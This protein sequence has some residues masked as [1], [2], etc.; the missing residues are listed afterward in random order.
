MCPGPTA[1]LL[2]FLFLAFAGAWVPWLALLWNEQLP[3]QIALPGLLAPALAAIVVTS[4]D[5]GAPAVRA[6]LRPLSQARFPFGYWLLAAGTMPLAYA[7][8]ALAVGSGHTGFSVSHGRAWWFLPISFIYLFG[9]TAG[10]EI[11]WRG[12]AVPRLLGLGIAPIRAS[13][14]VGAIWGIWHLPL[15]L[16]EAAQAR[17]LLLF[18]VLTM[19]LSVI[20]TAVQLRTSSLLP[21]LLIHASTDLMP[22]VIDT[23]SLGWKF[24]MVTDLIVVAIAG[25][26]HRRLMS[27]CDLRDEELREAAGAWSDRR[28]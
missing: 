17:D 20:Y 6:L 22:R 26:T 8:A 7:I 10:E 3:T 27:S 11:G 21:A 23:S 1:G 12:Y 5:G 18:M 25:A 16:M 4:R 19:S 9:I 13:L 28:A 15:R 14:L 2:L 24:W